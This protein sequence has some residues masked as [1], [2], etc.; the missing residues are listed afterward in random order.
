MSENEAK[1][2][3]NRDVNIRSGIFG[4]TDC[5]DGYTPT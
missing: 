2:E 4:I 5:I 1:I 3:R